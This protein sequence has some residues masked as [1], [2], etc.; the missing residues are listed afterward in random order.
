MELFNPEISSIGV[1]TPLVRSITNSGMKRYPVLIV[2]I[3]IVRKIKKAINLAIHAISMTT[4]LTTILH[5]G[6]Y[7]ITTDLKSQLAPTNSKA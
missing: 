5:T 3:A 1:D 6:K 2:M 7:T 4:T